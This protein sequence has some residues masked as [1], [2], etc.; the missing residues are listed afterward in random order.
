MGSQT[1]LSGKLGTADNT[2]D[3]L[4]DVETH[5]HQVLLEVSEV[6]MALDGVESGR[7]ERTV[8]AIEVPI[9]LGLLGVDLRLVLHKVEGGVCAETAETAVELLCNGQVL[10][11]TSLVVAGDHVFR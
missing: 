10:C 11:D 4:C 6:A 2:G 8:S 3:Q 9:L 5:F 7:P 1:I